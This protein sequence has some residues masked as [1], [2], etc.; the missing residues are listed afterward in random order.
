MIADVI[1]RHPKERLSKCSL[2]PLVGRPD[3]RFYKAKEGF[4]FDASG[5][6]VLGLEGETLSAADCGR[7]L[8]LLDSTWRLL[9]ALLRCLTGSIEFRTLPAVKTAYPRISKIDADPSRGLA[10]VEA[11]YL[12]RLLVGRKDDSLLNHYRWKEAFLRN[13]HDSLATNDLR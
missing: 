7:P 4:T 12:A 2:Q 11:L 9:P 1:L 5:F 6:L 10:S 13:L 8:L 3:L